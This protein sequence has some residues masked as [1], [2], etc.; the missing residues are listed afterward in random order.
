M[1]KGL[2]Q[3]KPGKAKRAKAEG[4]EDCGDDDADVVGAELD[5]DVADGEGQEQIVDEVVKD[6]V[7]MDAKMPAKEGAGGG[8][9]AELQ[10]H[11]V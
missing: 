8:E 3:S 5:E 2:S 6:A 10:L 1:V 9:G 7:M 11:Y 4:N